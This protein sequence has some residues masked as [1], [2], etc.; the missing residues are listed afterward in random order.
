MDAPFDAS[1]HAGRAP[2]SS[3]GP[4]QAD[5]L[6]A[7]LLDEIGEH[8]AQLARH[9]ARFHALTDLSNDPT[10]LERAKAALHMY[11][12][13]NAMDEIEKSLVRTE[14]VEMV[15]QARACAGYSRIPRR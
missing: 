4:R 2:R 15:P 13:R 11:C 14:A 9:S 8:A 7:R 12:A 10:S 5:T 6:R 1:T 3:R